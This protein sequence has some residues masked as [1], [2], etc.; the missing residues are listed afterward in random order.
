VARLRTLLM[1]ALLILACGTAALADTPELMAR[2]AYDAYTRGDY[3]ESLRLYTLMVKRG[4]DGAAV[5]YDLGNA[6][7][8]TGDLG[9]AILNY[10]RALAMDPGL[11][12]AR[13]NLGVARSLLPAR[14]AAW[15]PSPW[16]SA[17]R[18]LPPGRLEWAVAILA[19]L[20][21]LLLGAALLLGPGRTRRICVQAFVG[22]CVA[23][24]AA[25]GLLLY[26]DAALP[27][28]RPAVVVEA[29]PV[30]ASPGG[31]GEAIATLP[32]GSEVV[33]GSRAG[34]WILVQWGEGRGWAPDSSVEEP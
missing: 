14:A 24:G 3:A 1:A 33:A 17:L 12:P 15:Q 4:Y 31:E 27:S 25:L 19:G 30:Y 5:R 32:P 23:A 22:F 18:S 6:Y 26:A 11:E 21:N 9:R 34:R 13:H 28:H 20:A 7:M 16:E 8:R 2:Q 29:S 10:R